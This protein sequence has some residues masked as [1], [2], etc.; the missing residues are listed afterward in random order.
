MGRSVF[1]DENYCLGGQEVTATKNPYLIMTAR[2]RNYPNKQHMF[3]PEDI[4]KG[5]MDSVNVA[6]SLV[7]VALYG[8]LPINN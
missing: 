6:F 1:F 4:L 5:S 3:P 2:L 7:E 8:M